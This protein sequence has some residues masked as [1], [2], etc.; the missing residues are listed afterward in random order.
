LVVNL[1]VKG[2]IN[3]IPPKRL[4]AI[5]GTFHTI[6]IKHPFELH[7]KLIP[8]I[9]IGEVTGH[10]LTAKKTAPVSRSGFELLAGRVTPARHFGH[11]E[12]RAEGCQP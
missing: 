3:F 7:G 10:K 9:T 12:W 11:R 5:E 2:A 6:I 8:I 4:F 1:P